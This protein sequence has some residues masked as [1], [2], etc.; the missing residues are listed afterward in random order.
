[1]LPSLRSLAGSADEQMTTAT[2]DLSPQ[3]LAAAAWTLP[4]LY[5]QHYEL[6]AR[7]LPYLQFARAKRVSF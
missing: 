2:A 7:L 5:R 4:F 6:Q 3:Q 1:M